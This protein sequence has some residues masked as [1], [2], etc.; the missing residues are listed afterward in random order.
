MI[1]IAAPFITQIF[2]AFA[3]SQQSLRA[4]GW[5]DAELHP[6][7]KPKYARLS[8]LVGIQHLKSIFDD[9]DLQNRVWRLQHQLEAGEP[10]TGEM[11]ARELEGLHTQAIICLSKHKFAYIP[12]PG[13][14]YFERERLFGEDVY[15]R[16]PEARE[17]IKNAGNSLAAEL[18][19]AAVFY[20]MRA[21]EHGLRH[22]ARR[23]KVTRIIGKRPIDISET[24][25]ENLLRELRKK[26]EVAH[27]EKN[28]T[29]PRSK[30]IALYSD[31]ADHAKH[32]QGLWRNGVSHLEVYN[33]HEAMN[34][35]DRV[36][37]FMQLI[38]RG[39]A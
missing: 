10:F 32:M 8:C 15:V 13:D 16:L 25:W 4:D 20:L 26:L 33:I 24:T 31:A 3:T 35:F 12:S 17:D 28:I 6:E 9:D 34:V 14:E 29:A 23:M 30:R 38:A 19:T 18:H 11:L 36:K 5:K 1:D 22:I 2:S 27:Q 37:G 21:S 7:I 39:F